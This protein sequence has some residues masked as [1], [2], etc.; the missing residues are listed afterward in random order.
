MF[1][2]NSGI[3]QAGRYGVRFHRLAVRILQNVGASAVQYTNGTPGDRCC[4]ATG[5]DTVTARLETVET[6]LGVVDELGER[7]D[8]IRPTTDTCTNGVGKASNP[9]KALLTGLRRNDPLKLSHQFRERVWPRSGTDEVVGVLNMGHPIS[10][11]L[12]HG[13]LQR[14][15]AGFHCNDLGAQQLHASHIE[16]LTLG[17]DLAHIDPALHAHHRGHGRRRHA[18]LSNSRLC[19]ETALAH[20]SSQQGLAQHIVDLVRT[21]VVQVLALQKDSHLMTGLLKDVLRKSRCLC[22]RRGASGVLPAQI[23]Q[24][25]EKVRIGYR[26]LEGP[27]KLAKSSLESFWNESATETVEVSPSVGQVSCGHDRP[28]H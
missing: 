10:H 15:R 7:S 13:I 14:A 2:A 6:N 16:G 12:V 17:V 1:G 20:L 4:M 18:M 9:I 19:N 26:G 27:R 25:S 22:K 3:V 8:G 21:G 23:L 5:L 28:F 11:G 24:L